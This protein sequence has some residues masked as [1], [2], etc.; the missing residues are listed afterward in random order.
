MPTVSR[1]KAITRL[2]NTGAALAVAFALLAT[3]PAP[4]YAGSPIA[5]VKT[6]Y[7]YKFLRGVTWPDSAFASG[8]D[9]VVVVIVGQ[10]EL[11]GL[12]DKVAA[13]KKIGD[14][15]ISLVRVGSVAEA[16]KCQVLYLAGAA[17]PEEREAAL[18][19]AKSGGVLLIGEASGFAD[20][21][22]VLNFYQDAD[23]TTG[24]ELNQAAATAAGLQVEDKIATV[25]RLITK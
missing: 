6:A 9:P 19:V 16:P 2:A 20:E 15:T 23:G 12:F 10:D 21:G 8:D 22:A 1:T 3:N 25:A 17:S 5:K 7:L 13:K 24:F 14:R 11:E 4:A 18:G